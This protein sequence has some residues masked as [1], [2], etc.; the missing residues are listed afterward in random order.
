MKTNPFIALIIF[1]V[2]VFYFLPTMAQIENLIVETYYISDSLD[3]TDSTQ[4][5][6]IE[7]G[8]VTYRIYL[9]LAPGSK[10]KKIYGDQNHP[11]IISSTENFYNNIDRPNAYFGYLINRN[12]FSGNPTIGLDSW[13]TL[14][15]AARLSSA[16][17]YG[18]LK[19]ND[20]DGSFIGGN[21][22][23]GGTSGIPGGILINNDPE[24]GIPI[25]ANDGYMPGTAPS[26]QWFDYGFYDASLG[27]DTTVFGSLNTGKEFNSRIAVL[28]QGDGIMG[29]TSE[30]IVLVAQLTT[31]GQ[32]SFEL[33][34]QI[35]EADG[36]IVHYV[37]DDSVLINTTVPLYIE[38]LSPY[39]KYP[40]VCGCTD[41]DYLEYSA[42]YA[43]SNNDS[44]KTLIVFGCMDT[45]ACNYNPLANYNIKNL[46]CY[47]GYCADRDIEL[48][49][50]SLK[51]VR[52]MVA[53][54][55]AD[56]YL[57]WNL[58]GAEE[59]EGLLSIY[60]VSGR[61]MFQAELKAIQETAKIKVKEWPEGLYVLQI[62]T[63]DGK[64]H[65]KSFIISR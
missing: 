39:L 7:P 52:L 55:P 27:H 23:Q 22:N 29:K 11:L 17:Y 44:C 57:S 30:N 8:S 25:T 9:D 65:I 35:E 10:I 34:V 63:T 26:G 38:R 53:P 21:N 4:G 24:A 45:L 19:P 51:N 1:I 2:S 16:F 18:V 14:G 5:R 48:V 46:C 40:P 60:N 15:I 20:T 61:K 41:T 64:A 49:C 54:N 59:T 32:L 37:A 36:T 33:N 42:A 12:W 3:A 28:Q 6:T 47:P 56:D 31:K 43:C 50:P 58:T 62:I 13:L